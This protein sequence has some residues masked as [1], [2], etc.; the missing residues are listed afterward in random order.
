LLTQ[1]GQRANLTALRKPQTLERLAEDGVPPVWLASI[2]TLLAV[3]D[4]LDRQ[5]TPIEGE[6]RP[7][8]HGNPQVRLLMS[9]PRCR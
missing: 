4:D 5:I 9:I 1:W 8:A 7:I 6:L 3:I 2:R